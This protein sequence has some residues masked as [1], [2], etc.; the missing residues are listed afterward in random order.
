MMMSA[1]SHA[2][3]DLVV[4]RLVVA[5]DEIF[6]L[7]ER[8]FAEYEEEVLRSRFVQ[9]PRD[10]FHKEDFHLLSSQVQEAKG[11]ESFINKSMMMSVKTQALKDLVVER[12]VVAA[13]EIFELFERTFAQYEEEVLRS[14]YLPQPPEVIHKPDFQTVIVGLNV[15]TDQ[16]IKKESI[17]IKQE[18]DPPME[19]QYSSVTVKSEEQDPEEETRPDL[20]GEQ[21]DGEEPG[22]STDLSLD[23]NRRPYSCSDNDSDEETTKSNGE[24]PSTSPVKDTAENHVNN[25]NNNFSSSTI[26]VSNGAEKRDKQPKCNLCYKTFKSV[27]A[28]ERHLEFH[29]GPFTCEICNKVHSDRSN[30]KKHLRIHA[31][32]KPFRCSVCERGFTQKRHMNEHMRIHTGEKPLSC[33]D[34]G[35]TFR[36]KNSLM[37]HVLSKH[38]EHKP[39]SCPIC[40]KGFVQ[41]WHLVVH[42]RGHT[43]ERPFSCSVCDRS[44]ESKCYLKK[45]MD[46][47][48]KADG[49]IPNEVLDSGLCPTLDWEQETLDESLIQNNNTF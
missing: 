17:K 18:V 31:E 3:K 12:L 16:A 36:Q 24:E 25:A 34:C 28:L 29:P 30:Y 39:Y 23:N 5:A 1:K 6:A 45:H 32:Q 38:S 7:F 40:M 27:K 46:R 9:Q 2:P 33:S 42:M 21:C 15:G 26:I 44:F 48:H 13:D 20:S 8:T 11:S 10:V 14:R 22:C 37:R 49:E 47:N 43:G 4:E 19:L 41:K 35:M